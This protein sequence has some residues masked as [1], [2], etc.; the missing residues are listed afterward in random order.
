MSTTKILALALLIPLGFAASEPAH[1]NE[2]RGFGVE[3]S[4][5]DADGSGGL[6]LEEL[7]NIRQ[8][9]LNRAD[10]NGDGQITEAELLAQAN[11][12]AA[13]RVARLLERVDADQDGAITQEE[14]AQAREE[15]RDARRAAMAER[16]FERADAN[17]DGEIS[18]DEFEEAQTRMRERFGSGPGRFGDRG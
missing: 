13:E 1:A 18:A 10:A 6:S 16:L 2:G 17:G 4:D 15:R 12:Q 11:A 7:Q 8:N 14:I 3:F 5:L 9:M